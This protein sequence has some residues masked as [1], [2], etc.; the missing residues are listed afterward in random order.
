MS[1]IKMMILMYIIRA[2][3]GLLGYTRP[4]YYMLI[5]YQT[6]VHLLHFYPLLRGS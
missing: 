2:S 3:R 5:A 6:L 4:G 1:M